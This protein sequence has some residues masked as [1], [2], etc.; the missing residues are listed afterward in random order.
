MRQTFIHKL[1]NQTDLERAIY[2]RG[3]KPGCSSSQESCTPNI[4]GVLVFGILLGNFEEPFGVH[5]RDNR[6]ADPIIPMVI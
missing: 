6:E 1:R 5:E 3:I 2:V 4:R